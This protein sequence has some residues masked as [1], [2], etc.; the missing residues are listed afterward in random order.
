MYGWGVVRHGHLLGSLLLAQ[1]TL[2]AHPGA[3]FGRQCCRE[4]SE[5]SDIVKEILILRG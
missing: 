3:Q 4:R 1:E 5:L 2:R